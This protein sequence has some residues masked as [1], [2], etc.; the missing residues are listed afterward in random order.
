MRDS[1]MTDNGPIDTEEV[2]L[3][4][5]QSLLDAELQALK[6]HQF[7]EQISEFGLD[8]EDAEEAWWLFKERR[9]RVFG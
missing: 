5:W 3:A 2:A 8:G 1:Q 6:P 4:V 9:D 7:Y